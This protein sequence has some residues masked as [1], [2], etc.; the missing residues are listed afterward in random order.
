MGCGF[1][2]SLV[3]SSTETSP[4]VCETDPS[5]QAISYASCGNFVSALEQLY[6]S[7]PDAF[8]GEVNPLRLNADSQASS[9]DFGNVQFPTRFNWIINQ[10][11]GIASLHDTSPYLYDFEE[12]LST[13]KIVFVTSETYNGA[14][15]GLAGA[16]AICQGRADD[17][18]LPGTYRAWLS[19]ST[20]SVR[21]RFDRDY[22]DAPFV[23]TDGARVAN[24]WADLTDGT[25]LAAI[26]RD[27]FNNTGGAN[28]VWT[29]TNRGGN[30]R[31]SNDCNGWTSDSST[32]TVYS[33]IGTVSATNTLWTATSGTYGCSSRRSLYCFQQQVSF[34]SEAEQPLPQFPTH[35]TTHTSSF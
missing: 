28:Y 31:G 6:A 26:T 25:L 27:E 34:W 21:D 23:R 32:G 30:G 22:D 13:E 7:L 8:A 2:S 3:W 24:D 15:G 20:T 10:A 17:A 35:R 29:N 18:G 16:D 4:E 11:N 5:N 12:L 33:T 1:D 14:L 19:D 9:S